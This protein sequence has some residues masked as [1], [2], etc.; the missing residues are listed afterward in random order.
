MSDLGE[1]L[2]NLGFEKKG[3]ITLN[4]TGSLPEF[5]LSNPLETSEGL[6]YLWV[7]TE[8]DGKPSKIVYIGKAGKRLSKRC[9]E[10]M[11]GFKPNGGSKKGY[12]NGVQVLNLLKNNTKISIYARQSQRKEILG[13]PDISL[14]EAE[15]N[16][17]LK[18]YK[19]HPLLNGR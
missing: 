8:T 1:E 6:V 7:V 14:C 13:E 18:H 2:K 3:D 12:S 16:A 9:A 19:N 10:H 5:K 15:E 4:T 17:L 11:N